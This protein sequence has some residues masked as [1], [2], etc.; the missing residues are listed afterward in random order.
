MTDI[1]IDPASYKDPAGFVF[2]YLGKIYRCVH[3]SYAP[4]YQMLMQ[5]GLYA[6]LCEK[7]WLVPHVECTENIIAIP[8]AYKVIAPQPLTTISYVYEWSID[9]LKDAALLTLNINKAAVAHGM[10]LKDATPFNVQFV[11]GRPVF[12]DTLSFEEHN[13]AVTWVAYR[14]FCETFLFPLYLSRYL[15]TDINRLLITYIDGIP[16][17]VAAKLLPARSRLNLGVWLHVHL[18]NVVKA[19]GSRAGGAGTFT[20]EKLLQ[21]VQHLHNSI[22]ALPEKDATGT[23]GDYYEK[24][25]LSS[26][27]LQAKE[28]VFRSFLD[29]IRADRALD[30]GANDG[31]FSRILAE[32]I[33]EVIATDADSGCINRLYTAVK[34]K[35]LPVVPLITDLCNPSPG[36]GFSNLER[37]PFLLRAV[38]E[39]VIAL[40]LVH[41]LVFGRNVPLTMVAGLMQQLTR[42][43]LIVEFVPMEDEKVQQLIQHKT[44][45]HLPYDAATFE[46]VFTKYFT[47]ERKET[48]SASSRILYRMKK[49]P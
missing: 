14:Q 19:K 28:K 6:H 3:P 34:K 15:N 44:A 24:T 1:D 20:K 48:I 21:L 9:M 35:R 37:T 27:Y 10:I 45:W 13:P 46:Q 30:L 18:Q 43:Y 33:P 11:K 5:S 40:A 8:G 49:L 16:A 4:H 42:V 25:I 41:H 36:A 39:V 22:A 2:Q 7:Q 17:S 47:I 32:T 23:W 26:A 29:G 38:S 12:I 31:Y